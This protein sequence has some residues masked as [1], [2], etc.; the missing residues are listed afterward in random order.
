VQNLASKTLSLAAADIQA[1]V[2]SMQAEGLSQTYID[3]YLAN[4]QHEL[5]LDMKQHFSDFFEGNVHPDATYVS[6]GITVTPDYQLAPNLPLFNGT[7][8]YG[9][10]AQGKEGDCWLMASLAEVAARNPGDIESMFIDNG[11]NTYTVRFY[12]NGTPDYVTVDKYLPDGGTD[13][14]RPQGSLWAALAEKAYA[15][16]N[17][18][19]WIGSSH[20][21][22]DSYA[23]LYGG[24]PD[25][26]LAAITGRPSSYYTGYSGGSFSWG[27]PSIPTGTIANDWAQGM[28]VVLCTGDSPGSS[29][30][31]PDHCYAMVNYVSGWFTFFNPWGLSGN[32]S[33]N[34]TYYPGLIEVYA[35]AIGDNFNSW[36]QGY[37]AA[38]LDT[39]PMTAVAGLNQ[40]VTNP[41]LSAA[42]PN[43]RN[44]QNF[45]AASSG[46]PMDN[47]LLAALI[48]AKNR[49]AASTP[50]L[51]DAAV[52]GAFAE[53]DGFLNG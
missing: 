50:V 15:Q 4:D 17:A 37:S 48:A 34:G 28:F 8:G 38:G 26:A 44:L 3:N 45:L 39:P 29:L 21:G 52:K 35:S 46:L 32:T 25:W 33:S 10:V 16:E 47:A 23:A 18:A 13:F 11:D 2:N 30:V 36:A 43:A 1:D 53:F 31:V 14:D 49:S 22:V 51:P 24:H 9:D 5:A 7:P 41:L 12:D 42:L 20:P 27:G 40:P 19:G 6:N